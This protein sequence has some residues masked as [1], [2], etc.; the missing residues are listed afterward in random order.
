MKYK[1]LNELYSEVQIR[2]KNSSAEGCSIGAVQVDQ[3]CSYLLDVLKEEGI[4]V[5]KLLNIA[6]KYSEKD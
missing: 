3:V 4:D 6:N 2:E 5:R 1:N